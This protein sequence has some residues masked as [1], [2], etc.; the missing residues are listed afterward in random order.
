M[1]Q[2]QY[3]GLGSQFVSVVSAARGPHNA[4]STAS[5]T[6]ITQDLNASDKRQ[7]TRMFR[8]AS[9]M[10]Q[11][12]APLHRESSNIRLKNWHHEQSRFRL[13]VAAAL[14]QSD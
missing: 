6:T 8:N 10:Q 9:A 5:M 7:Q 2:R 4:H 1:Q 3:N 13:E 12:S 11:C 14:E